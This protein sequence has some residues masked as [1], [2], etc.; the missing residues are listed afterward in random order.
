MEDEERVLPIFACNV[1]TLAVTGAAL[2]IAFVVL[3]AAMRLFVALMEASPVAAVALV[4][5][6]IGI[7]I[8]VGRGDDN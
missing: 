7:G 3:W 5:A 6:L 8:Y 2:V 1:H 4:V